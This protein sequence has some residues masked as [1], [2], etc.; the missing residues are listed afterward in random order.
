MQNLQLANGTQKWCNLKHMLAGSKSKTS[1][2]IIHKSKTRDKRQ[3]SKHSFIVSNK[4][5]QNMDL[6][7][8]EMA[9]IEYMKYTFVDSD[10]FQDKDDADNKFL[11]NEKPDLFDYIDSI[12]KI[13]F[14]TDRYDFEKW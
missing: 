10:E 3:Q 5:I 13:E 6:T 11:Q 4:L 14:V 1:E 12:G 8:W 7:I 2:N 9:D